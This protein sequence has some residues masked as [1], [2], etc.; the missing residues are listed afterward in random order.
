ML[1]HSY[2]AHFNVDTI[3]ALRAPDP[4]PAYMSDVYAQTLHE[5]TSIIVHNLHRCEQPAVEGP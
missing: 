2:Y 5:A 1:L 4:S 3:H